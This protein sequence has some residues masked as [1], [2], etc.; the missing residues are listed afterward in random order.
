MRPNDGVSVHHAN[1]GS[2]W[3]AFDEG[4]HVLAQFL[5]E[6]AQYFEEGG[7]IDCRVR[8]AGT[9]GLPDLPTFLQLPCQPH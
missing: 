8:I 5:E 7:R 6:R 4:G 1:H 3:R 2:A 9:E